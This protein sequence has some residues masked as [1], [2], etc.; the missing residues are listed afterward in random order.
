M[1]V[2]P[3]C[4]SNAIK[5]TSEDCDYFSGVACCSDLVRPEDCLGNDLFVAYS[6]CMNSWFLDKGCFTLTCV[7]HD[8]LEEDLEEDVEE[9]VE[10]EVVDDD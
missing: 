4:L 10:E 1:S 8:D 6:L 3:I 5:D 7:S 2:E 9:V